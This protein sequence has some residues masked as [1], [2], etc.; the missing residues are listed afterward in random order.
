LKQSKTIANMVDQKEEHQSQKPVI[1]ETDQSV[2]IEEKIIQ[3]DVNPVV[4]FEEETHQFIISE[5]KIEQPVFPDQNDNKSKEKSAIAEVVTHKSAVFEQLSP[6]QKEDVPTEIGKQEVIQHDGVEE[7]VHLE[8]TK[9]NRLELLEQERIEQERIEAD[10]INK[11]I[12]EAKTNEL[13]IFELE[14]PEQLEQKEDSQ[15]MITDKKF[16]Q[17]ENVVQKVESQS[18]LI[19][20]N[21]EVQSEIETIFEEVTISTPSLKVSEETDLVDAATPDKELETIANKSK[22]TETAPDQK[23][24]TPDELSNTNDKTDISSKKGYAGKHKYKPVPDQKKQTPDKLPNTNDKSDISSKKVPADKLKNKTVPDHKKEIE[25]IS[26]NQPAESAKK[27]SEKKLS[28]QPETKKDFGK[29]QASRSPKQIAEKEQAGQDTA[30]VPD[31]VSKDIQNIFNGRWSDF[32]REQQSGQQENSSSLLAL[33]PSGTEDQ[34][35]HILRSQILF[36]LENSRN[37]V[38]L[39][40]GSHDELQHGHILKPLVWEARNGKWRLPFGS[41]FKTPDMIF[42]GSA[43]ES[44]QPEYLIWKISVCRL[45]KENEKFMYVVPIEADLHD[46]EDLIYIKKKMIVECDHL[47]YLH[48]RAENEANDEARLLSHYKVQ[49]EAR[50]YYQS[51]VFTHSKDV[52]SNQNLLAGNPEFGEVKLYSAM[53]VPEVKN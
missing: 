21:E 14:Q 20:F 47:R 30:D 8:R 39:V 15:S 23:K 3:S 2:I 51:I 31:K 38:A 35:S 25:M 4:I 27:I 19:T 26:V 11:M 42:Y 29:K 33:K 50:I 36:D 44:E 34:V 5:Q 53:I 28:N 7:P 12:L 46:D 16:D 22:D 17:S 43:G 52:E 40:C 9:P 48:E 32:L 18:V 49:T 10:K 41:N 1:I 37:G 24:Q 6:A 13:A 45:N